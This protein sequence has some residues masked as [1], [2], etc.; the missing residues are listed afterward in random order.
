MEKEELFQ[1][2]FKSL[3]MVVAQGAVVKNEAW[4]YLLISFLQ[5]LSR[6]LVS[7]ASSALVAPSLP[8][9]E[10][11]SDKKTVEQP[12]A[13]STQGAPQVLRK[14]P[15]KIPKW[16]KLPGINVSL[17]WLVWFRLVLRCWWRGKTGSSLFPISSML[18]LHSWN[19]FLFQ[20]YLEKAQN[21]I[22]PTCA[23]FPFNSTYEKLI[24]CSKLPVNNMKDY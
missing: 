18:E 10:V 23:S 19:S 17:L 14:A 21:I 7:T 3:K 1:S 6:S 4:F 24:I 13:A 22:S 16:L 20:D 5:C 12:E 2:N 11:R 8:D 9:P 15:G